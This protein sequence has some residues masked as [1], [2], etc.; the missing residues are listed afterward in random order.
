MHNLNSQQHL[1]GGGVQHNTESCAHGL[2][3]KVAA[4]LGADDT[5]VSVRSDNLTPDHPEKRSESDE[6]MNASVALHTQGKHENL[7]LRPLTSRWAR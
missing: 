4:E 1:D 2:G 7:C 5:T 3:G 6:A